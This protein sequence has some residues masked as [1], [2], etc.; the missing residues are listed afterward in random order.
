MC[1]LHSFYTK[2]PHTS[3]HFCYNAAMR[4]F[5]FPI[6]VAI[7]G[8]GGAYLWG[9][10]AA[11]AT[12]AILALL[13]TT[14]SFDNAVMNANV[15]KRMSPLWQRRFLI[16]G[17]PIA[18]FGA[19]LVLPVLI[20]AAAAGLS[21]LLV[22][23]LAIF[24]PIRYGAYVQAAHVA[25]AAF[26]S[27]FLLL[28]S[29]RY[30]FDTEKK[31]HWIKG[32]E[33]HLSRWGGIDAIEV[34]LVLAILLGSAL[35]MPSEA[36]T[37]LIAGLIGVILFI[38]T[39]GIAQTFET[40]VTRLAHAGIATFVYLEILDA[41][42]SLDGVV[43]AFA[44]TSML[45]AIIVGLGIGSIFVRSFTISLVRHKTL[46]TL[47]YLE[48]GAHWAIFG[49]AIAMV[50]SMFVHVPGMITGSIGVIFIGLAY[51]SSRTA[52]KKGV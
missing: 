32:I 33:Q 12:V 50:A 19:R 27:T 14:L 48:H 34:A 47:M 2:T 16:W 18:V 6:L 8:I 42:F 17:I 10:V 41:T 45:P 21:P 22:G 31:V 35:L 4:Q 49:L 13:E 25:I 24:D 51:L 26:G 36:T 40:D 30:F 38:M 1:H 37:I 5:A 15:L 44:I 46:D 9:G 20:V 23:Q 28:V 29:C 43:G 7:V 39:E 11:C 3:T 52:I